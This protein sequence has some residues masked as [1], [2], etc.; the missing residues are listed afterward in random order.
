MIEF[1]DNQIAFKYKQ[2]QQCGACIAVCPVDA[3]SFVRN[4][5]GLAQINVDHEKCIRCLK[6]LRTCPANKRENFSQYF[7]G[8]EEKKYFLG[9]NSDETIRIESSSGGVCKT[10]I[11][12]SLK[13]GIVDGVYSL[14]SLEEY[15][16]AVGEFYTTEN[17]PD[18]SDFPNSV[19]HSILQCLELAKVKKVSRLMI[20]GTSCQLKALETALKGKFEKLIK[21][22]IFCK[23]QKNLDSTHYFAKALKV[24]LPKDL[25][26]YVRYRGKGW[27]GSVQ[28]GEKTIL[29]HIAAQLPFGRRLWTV[30]GCNICGDPFGFNANSDLSLMDP[31]SIEKFGTK[32]ETLVTVSTTTGADLLTNCE[33]LVL[34][35]KTYKEIEPA[36]DLSDIRRKQALVPFFR[37]EKCTFKIRM[38]GS[39]EKFQRASLETII[40]VLPSMPILFYRILCKASEPFNK[41]IKK[42]CLS[43]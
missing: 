2:C 32:G 29:W 25:R 7:T 37:E 22:C 3:L 9:Y 28:V 36:L 20:I 11:I 41:I 35:T 40:D 34:K 38:A 10:L 12:N 43:K 42:L 5:K 4:K 39:L 6:C 16:S 14:K 1:I 18:Y 15:P 26:F 21:V 24:N 27:P 19:Y 13:N 31:W 33:S 23:Q 30:P 17:I 8:I